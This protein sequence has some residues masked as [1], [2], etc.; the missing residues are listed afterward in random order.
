LTRKGYTADR[1]ITL[2][3]PVNFVVFAVLLIA[4][5]ATPAWSAVL[6]ALVCVSCTVAAL[7]QPAVGMAFQP[8]LAGRAL[9]AYNLVIF[10]GVF[11]VQW[12]IGLLLDGFKAFG[13]AEVAAYQAAFGI[14][15]LACVG[16][17]VYFLRAK[18]P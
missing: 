9:S 4:G 13:V 6:L 8:E 12:G 2:G 16:A 10:S 15:G 11:A 14:Y 3:M 18:A 1:L 5:D 7:A 17:Y